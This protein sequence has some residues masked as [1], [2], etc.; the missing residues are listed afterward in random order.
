MADLK[1]GLTP[2]TRSRLGQLRVQGVS[3]LSED[4]E[5]VG[6]ARFAMATL[7]TDELTLHHATDAGAVE[8]GDAGVVATDVSCSGDEAGATRAVCVYTTRHLA[9]SAL[10]PITVGSAGEPVRNLHITRPV[11]PKAGGYFP[12]FRR[13]SCARTPTWGGTHRTC[14]Q[15]NEIELP[16]APWIVERLVLLCTILYVL[17]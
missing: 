10:L 9:P 7:Y 2:D 16:A 17:L 5:M 6:S 12:R 15:P 14:R 13:L 3:S 1:H 11:Q 4:V 8:L